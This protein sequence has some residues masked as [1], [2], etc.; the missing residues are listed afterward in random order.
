VSR[1]LPQVN[2][3]G[4]V[5]TKVMTDPRSLCIERMRVCT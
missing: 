2:G 3:I 5:R 4:A 1:S